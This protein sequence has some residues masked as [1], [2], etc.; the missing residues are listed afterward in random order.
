MK[1]Q[2]WI[3]GCEGAGRLKEEETGCEGGTIKLIWLRRAQLIHSFCTLQ[4]IVV[5]KF[6]YIFKN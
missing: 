4:V 5:K 3:L 1:K 2:L 6:R